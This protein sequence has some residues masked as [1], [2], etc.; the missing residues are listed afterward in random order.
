MT[1]EQASEA[2]WKARDLLQEIINSGHRGDKEAVIEE[3]NYEDLTE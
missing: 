1:E 3:L 2:Y